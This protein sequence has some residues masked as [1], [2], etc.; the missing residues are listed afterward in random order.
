[1]GFIVKEQFQ[2]YSVMNNSS[3]IIISIH[4]YGQ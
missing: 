4:D 1:M 3:Q 2:N